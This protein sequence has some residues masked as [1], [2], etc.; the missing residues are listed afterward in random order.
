[1]A[2]L[3]ALPPP[4]GGQVSV[5]G[6]SADLVDTLDALRTRLPWMLLVITVALFGLLS[7]A[8][9]SVVLP[10]KAILTTAVSVGASFGVMVWVFQDGHLHSLLG[11]VPTGSLDADTLVLILAMLLGL[12]TDYEVF[13]LSRIRE[14]YDR[15][16]DTTESVALGL[17]RTGGI[18]TSAALLLIIVVAGFTTGDLLFIK[19]IGVGTTV[20]IVVDAA[21]VRPLLVPATLRLLGAANWWA[22]GVLARRYR[23][24]GT[25]SDASSVPDA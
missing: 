11:F 13:L 14:Q 24:Y 2:A 21:R 3:R 17:Q 18:I 12:S 5:A 22:P 15:S 6:T 4:P 10:V 1:M 19:E 8:F 25:C 7:V 23:R 16:G 9:G 20:A